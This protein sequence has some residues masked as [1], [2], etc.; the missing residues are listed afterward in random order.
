MVEFI[1][2]KPVLVQD[3]FDKFQVSQLNC[4]KEHLGYCASLEGFGCESPTSLELD[5]REAHFFHE[6]HNPD[7]LPR[8]S[9]FFEFVL[10]L[11]FTLL[12]LKLLLLLSNFLQPGFPHRFVHLIL[13][14]AVELTDFRFRIGCI[15]VFHLRFVL[16]L[17]HDLIAYFGT[18]KLK[19]VHLLL[20]LKQSLG[21]LSLELHLILSHHIYV[22]DI[23]LIA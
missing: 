9:D 4:F 16:R 19:V 17:N 12:H 23:R 15:V 2:S 1:H 7:H 20:L 10:T 6:S 22:G 11:L 8:K 3:L 21:F 18:R 5:G 14:S 13:T